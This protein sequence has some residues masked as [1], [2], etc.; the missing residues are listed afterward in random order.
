MTFLSTLKFTAVLETQPSPIEKKRARLIANLRDQ[1]TRLENPNHTK[2]R[3]KWVKE[4]TER[5]LIEKKSPVRP[6]WRETIDGQVAFYVRAGLK[7]VE[8]EKGMTAILV[9]NRQELPSLIEGLIKAVG[10][11]ELDNLIGEKEGQKK[12]IRKKVA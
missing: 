3:T 9:P 6:W 5:R 10:S 1:L 4:G 7:K 11:G 12:M 2:I 8:F